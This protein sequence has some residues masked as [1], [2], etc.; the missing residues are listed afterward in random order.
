[1]IVNLTPHTVNLKLASGKIK[2]IERKG[3]IP[4]IEEVIEY[5]ASI[6]DVMIYGI[7]YGGVVDAPPVRPNTCY[8]VSRMIAEALPGRDDLLFPI[9]LE[10]DTNGSVLLATALGRIVRR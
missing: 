9:M 7:S 6:D 4:R 8:V 3:R 10:R 5:Q 2:T 1:M